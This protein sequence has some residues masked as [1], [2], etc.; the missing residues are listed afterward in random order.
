M[1]EHPISLEKAVELLNGD[2]GAVY[3]NIMNDCCVPIYWFYRDRDNFSIEHSGTLTIARTPKKIIG[4]TAAHVISQYEE[5]LKNGSLRL[6]LMNEVVDDLLERLICVSEKLDLA[7]FTLDDELVA[8]LGKTPLGVWPPAPP[9]EGRGI[10][11]A[12]YPAVERIESKNFEVNFGLFTVIG[13]ARR[14][15]DKQIS[16]LM[17]RDHQLETKNITAPPPEYS[18]GGISGGPLISWFESDNFVA[19][20]R[21]SGI[22]SEHPDYKN[23]KDMPP[24]ERII[25]IRADSISES[26][27]IFEN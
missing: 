18:L 25:A 12:G 6:Q 14:V 22:V 21:L 1:P 4:I 15:T 9:E 23:N 24:I 20:H 26:G 11:I 8:R 10:M 17:E 16:W 13:I 5:D 7:T 27:K 3:R 2:L 19:H